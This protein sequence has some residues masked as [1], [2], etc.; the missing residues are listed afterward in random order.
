MSDGLRFSTR[1]PLGFSAWQR[2]LW[3]LE[4]E[5][6]I[7]YGVSFLKILGNISYMFRKELWQ[8]G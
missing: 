6:L 7:S 5:H 1:S 4:V 3:V 2:V 8:G